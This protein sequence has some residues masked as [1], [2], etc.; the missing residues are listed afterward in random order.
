[1]KH[2]LSLLILLFAAGTSLPAQVSVEQFRQPEPDTHVIAWWHW[3][4]GSPVTTL[5]I[6]GR[7]VDITGSVRSG[8]NLL[9]ITVTNPWRNRLIGDLVQGGGSTFTTSPA[10]IKNDPVPVINP[11]ATLLPSGISEPLI[12]RIK[13]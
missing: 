3:L 7:E 8:A 4:N 5:W 6:P 12:I 1:M 2:I 11:A 13:K 10:T 9:T